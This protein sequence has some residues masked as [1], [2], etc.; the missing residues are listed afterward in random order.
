M[1][2]IVLGILLTYKQYALGLV[3]LIL[4]DVVLGIALAI[5][6]NKFDWR[7]VGLFYRSMVLPYIIGW[8]V[9]SVVTRIVAPEVLG[10]FGFLVGDVV[11]IGSWLAIVATLAGS[12]IKNA[13]DLYG[14]LNPFPVPEVSAGME[15]QKQP[16]LIV[17]RK[18]SQR[19][20]TY[21]DEDPAE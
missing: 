5:K 4:L 7:K 19:M 13:K 15:I 17:K 16:E 2:E 12:I 20:T 6:I 9:I 11:V 10:D 21:P 14:S 18:M 8:L 3:G 1:L